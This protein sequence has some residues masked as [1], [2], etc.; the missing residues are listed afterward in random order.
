M[1]EVDPVSGELTPVINP[2]TNYE[3]QPDGAGCR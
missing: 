2:A 3:Q 1:G